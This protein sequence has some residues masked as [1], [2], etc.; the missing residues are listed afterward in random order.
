ML[1]ATTT[2]LSNLNKKTQNNNLLCIRLLQQRGPE[3]VPGY[4]VTEQEVVVLG[5]QTIVDD[6]FRPRAV[7]EEREVENPRVFVALVPLLLLVVGHD[8]ERSSRFTFYNVHVQSKLLQHTH[9]SWA[10]NPVMMG[11]TH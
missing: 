2:D 8:L 7:P 4:R 3:F 1:P 11:W 10:H 6:H 9:L 5:R